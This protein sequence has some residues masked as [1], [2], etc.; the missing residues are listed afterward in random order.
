M[1]ARCML[2]YLTHIAIAITEKL[3]EEI[4]RCENIKIDFCEVRCGSNYLAPRRRPI[5]F[6]FAHLKFNMPSQIALDVDWSQHLK[7]SDYDYSE[8]SMKVSC[9]F[10]MRGKLIFNRFNLFF[11]LEWSYNKHYFKLDYKV[12][13]AKNLFQTI[14]LGKIFA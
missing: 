11:L 4:T 3:H 2:T 5:T 13:W 1:K 8:N 12:Y 14:S 9:K 7:P 6:Y 10:A